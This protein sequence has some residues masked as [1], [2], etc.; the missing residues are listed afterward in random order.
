M[1]GARWLCGSHVGLFQ[2][3]VGGSFHGIQY[4]F[5][6]SVCCSVLQVLAL[7]IAVGL[8]R[9]DVGGSWCVAVCCGVCCGV[10]C[11]VG[12]VNCCRA[13]SIGYWGLVSPHTGLFRAISVLQCVFQC[14]RCGSL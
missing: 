8:F 13:L 4:S 12:V 5:E 14:V 7:W 11:S 3:D 10:C 9:S 1:A 2:S 6:P